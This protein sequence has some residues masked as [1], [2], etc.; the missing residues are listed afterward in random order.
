MAECRR[1]Q[2]GATWQIRLKLCTLAQPREYDWTCASFG[3]PKSTTQAANRSVQPFLHNS[4]L[5]AP[6]LYN[7][8]PFPPK[9]PFLM[10]GCGPPSNSWFLGPVQAHNPH[11][12]TNGS[13]VFTQVTTECPYTLQ[14]AAASPLPSKLPL[15]VEVSG[16]HL[17]HGSRGP[18]RSSTQMASRS[19]FLQGS[20][21]WHTDRQTDRPTDHATRS[22][23]IDCI[24]IPSTVMRPN[25][26]VTK[27]RNM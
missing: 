27:S 26:N 6:M 20:L 19:P 13:A 17:I 3:P 10:G 14:W 21:V 22:V 15:P 5:K 8:R 1:V 16:P 12:I 9:L 23:T 24:Y 4:R 2:I 7:G 25:N 18:P 11:G